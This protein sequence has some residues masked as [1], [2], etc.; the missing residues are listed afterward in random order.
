MALT[1]AEKLAA[2]IAAMAA[3]LAG[4][5]VVKPPPP[6]PPP[7]VS[8][9]S[10]TKGFSHCF[11]VEQVFY[12]GDSLFYVRPLGTSSRKALQQAEG[13]PDVAQPYGPQVLI[14]TDSVQT[15]SREVWSSGFGTISSAIR[16]TPSVGVLE[17]NVVPFLYA[18][19]RATTR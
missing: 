13:V 2:A 8:D 14:C 9:S 6:P 5:S 18:G 7:V 10:A 16:T 1:P 11:T 17:R 19:A 4:V 12:A 15:R 3:V